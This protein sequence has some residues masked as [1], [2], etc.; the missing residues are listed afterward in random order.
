MFT[1]AYPSV[2]ERD[3]TGR[4]LVGF[5]DFPTARTDGANRMEAMEEAIDCLGSSIAFAIADKVDVPKPSLQ[6]AGDRNSCPCRSGL[7]ASWH[8]IG[9]S[10]R[11]ASARANWLAVSKSG[12]LSCAECWTQS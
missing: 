12:K 8:C 11:L 1:F 10:E 4:I 6:F 5:P 9:R 3:E 7:S 2:F